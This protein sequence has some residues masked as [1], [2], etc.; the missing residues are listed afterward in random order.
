MTLGRLLLRSLWRF[1]RTNLGVLLGVA[2]A[3]TVITGALIVGDSMRYT[4]Q[5]TADER[6]GEVRYAV[7]GGDRFFTNGLVDGLGDD[8]AG[9]VAVTG[10]LST[11]DGR[12]RANDVSVYGI[13]AG[14][15]DLLGGPDKPEPGHAV[16]NDV[17]AARLNAGIGDTL[18]LRVPEPS[19]LPI[20]AALVNASE[21]AAALRLTVA[22]IVDAG[23][24]G[25]F[26]LRAEQ[27]TPTNLYVDR[28][29]LAEQLGVAG[30]VNA[31]LMP[32]A[33]AGLDVTLDD[34]E[35]E[36]D[37]R[38]D[39]RAGLTT[40]RVFLDA[41]I[42]DDLDD[43]PGQRI[44]T[45]MVNTVA[46]GDQQ[47]PYAMV[48]AVSALGDLTLGDNEIAINRWLADDIGA[49]VG[50][51]L[52]LTYYV[53][54]EGDR[55]VETS[56]NLTVSRIVPLAG[57]YADRSL[58][59]DFPGL[60]EAENLSRW[61][62]GPAIDRRRIR[63]KD[64]AYWDDYRATPKAFISL[65]T[66]QRLWA[67]RFGT[68]TAIRFDRAV[69]D[70]E[71]TDRIDAEP[72]GFVARDVGAQAERAAAGT[73]DFGQLF[74]SLSAFIIVA[75]VVLTATL[76]A[77]S[78]EQ[79]ARQLGTLLAVGL[80]RSQVMRLILGEG[81]V[82]GVVGV[83][84]GL[85][86][87][88]YYARSVVGALSGVWSG[89]VAGTPVVMHADA[90]S[91]I[92]GPVGA[93]LISALAMWLSL[94]S[95]VR[96][97][98]RELLSGAVGKVS[99]RSRVPDLIVLAFAGALLLIAGATSFAA[100]SFS[101]MRAGMVGFMAG[102]ALLA[103]LLLA[104]DAL[105]VRRSRS[106]TTTRCSLSLARLSLL[107]LARRRGRTLAAVV[108][109]GAGV[110]LVLA[111]AGFRLN[112]ATDPSER[113]SG[114]G[115]FALIVEATQP[116]RYDLNTKLGRDHYFFDEDELP[117]GS[118]V[119]FRVNDG[120]DAS[121][122]NLNATPTPRVIG[123]DPALLSTRDAFTF[124]SPPEHDAG[125]DALRR[126]KDG[127]HP[128]RGLSPFSAPVPAIADANTAQWALKLAVGDT[129]ELTD[130]Q[131]RPYTIE[132]VGTVENSILQGSL[133]IDERAFERLYPT[134]SGHRMLLV[135]AADA[136]QRDEVAT[137]LEQVLV[138]EGVTVTPT[139]ARLAEYNRV[140]NTY[141]AI[142][143][144]LGGL[145]V[146]LGALGLGVIAARNLL[147]R[148]A[149]L[150]LFAAVGLSRGRI[151]LL[152]LIEHGVL[153]AAGLG[154]GLAASWLATLH[155]GRGLAGT[156]DAALLTVGAALV[157]GLI[158]VAVGLGSAWSGRLT[159]AL[160]ND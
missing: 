98:A 102:G 120:D 118:V 90:A 146:V 76:F 94:R 45:Y 138:D 125:W 70:A 122:L 53:P 148:R 132:L 143:Q 66:G 136:K 58:T 156:A 153:L 81:A 26:S 52:T 65:G 61:D 13:D 37:P 64:E 38:D 12:A 72:L 108:T 127:P 100:M 86:G 114:T 89:A 101:G 139:P 50:D 31:A 68:L 116:I 75:A 27:R 85:L 42:E 87:G 39:D 147:E 1:R 11:P 40:P 79:R 130:G 126:K 109:L 107:S 112:I 14:F 3:T 97:P 154:V 23:G 91:L 149:E 158:A 36:R 155:T 33:P 152:A 16:L 56:T 77:M 95:L 62:A 131:G 129:L 115:G 111:V 106:R 99:G 7:I 30:R 60:A 67:N 151:A 88:W 150:A 160:R 4:L 74:L 134:T 15:A 83:G 113:A 93:L 59:P 48:S 104:L 96:R 9:V 78:A 28:A 144:A 145:G 20:D 2:V 133:I 57:V 25:R 44:L 121:C 84:L 22:G 124:Q 35:L 34:L 63:D 46:L 71:L 119:P 73:V 137:L 92:V 5:Q 128:K 103:A 157:A 10:V 123:V 17:L 141:L 8:A 142:F 110:F 135:D 69:T 24:G 82:V 43:L 47:S 19:A 80:T 105:L 29:W 117:P 6:L 55:L 18:V 49:D 21:P 32:D 51:L 159:D 140:Q 41:S 54:D